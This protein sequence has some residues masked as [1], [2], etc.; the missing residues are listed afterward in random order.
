MLGGSIDHAYVIDRV[1]GKI[2]LQKHLFS[3]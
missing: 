2:I 1:G 3:M